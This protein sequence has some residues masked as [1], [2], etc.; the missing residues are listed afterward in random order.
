MHTSRRKGAIA[1]AAQSRTSLL[2]M[3]ASVLALALPVTAGDASLAVQR[4]IHSGQP[5]CAKKPETKST[6]V[7]CAAYILAACELAASLEQYKS[8]VK[9][10]ADCAEMSEDVKTTPVTEQNEINAEKRRLI[11]STMQ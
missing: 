10:V 9:F 4:L 8:N 6:D 3:I 5:F 11:A 1:M 2:F 7:K